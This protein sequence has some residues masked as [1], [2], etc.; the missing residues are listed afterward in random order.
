MTFLDALNSSAIVAALSATVLHFL[1][2]G[3]LIGLL[4]GAAFRSTRRASAQTRYVIGCAALA[5]SIVAFLT[6]FAIALASQRSP[7]A[8]GSATEIIALWGERA[9]QLPVS[10]WYRPGLWWA[11][12]LGV[13]VMGV[14]LQRQRMAVR[15][16][17]GSGVRDVDDRWRIP[18][19]ALCREMRLQRPARL[20]QSTLAEVPMVIGW[21][22]PVVLVPLAAFVSLTRDQLRSILA[23]EIAHIRRHDYL[24]NGLQKTVETVLFFHPVVWWLS[25][26]VRVEREHCCDDEVVQTLGNTLVYANALARVETLRAEPQSIALAA[27]GGS[28]MRRITRIV[29]ADVPAARSRLRRLT[30]AVTVAGI[31]LI[32]A[33]IAYTAIDNAKD[34][35]TDEPA[36]T[37]AAR[38]AY[39]ATDNAKDNATDEPAVTT[40][41]S[42][43]RGEKTGAVPDGDRQND[44]T[45]TQRAMI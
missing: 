30:A 9:G 8:P 39:T 24:I 34:N 22:S 16:L 36:V 27:N 45:L 11:W 17:R 14:R 35:P 31:A 43:D 42:R 21:L 20:M 23:H 38:V 7:D 10:D 40:A 28:L 13:G 18:F 32:T 44:G 37:T 1:W 5:V 2:Q 3:A 6:T 12:L 19:E 4:A 29:R 15:R 26:R 33:G 41:D 25:H